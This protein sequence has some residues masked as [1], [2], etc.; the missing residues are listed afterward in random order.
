MMQVGRKY[1]KWL[2]T[3]G[4]LAV[5]AM[6]YVSAVQSREDL[7]KVDNMTDRMKTVCVGR[8]LIDVPANAQVNLRLGLVQG[9]EVARHDE[10][11]E[12]FATRLHARET[13]LS[14]K[15]NM[16][17][18]KNIESIKD[19]Q[20]LGFSGKVFVHGRYRGYGI[21][22]GQRRYFETISVEGYVHKAG[23][24][25]SFMANTYDPDQAGV[26]PALLT[27]LADRAEND[28]PSDPGFCIS[29]A[30]LRDSSSRARSES[31]AMSAS[32]PGHPDL[33]ILFWTNSAA[34]QG[35]SL[36]KRHEAAMG[37]LTRAR[38]RTLRE[39]ERT[40]N[41][42]AGEEV[43]IK[44]TELNFATVFSFVW[45]TP[46]SDDNV[47]IPHLS[48]EL[49][50]GMSPQAGGA[51]VQS[52]LSEEAVLLLWNKVSSSIRLRPTGP[53]KVA[54]TGTPPPPLGTLAEA[55]DRCPQSGW[56]LCNDASSGV[57]VLGG[58][59][60]YLC[61]G[62]KM[63]QA[64]LL[65][66][67]TLWQR[68]RGLQSSYE[69]STRT[70]W[71]LVDKR[72]RDRSVPALPLA[73]ATLA[74][75]ASGN[76]LDGKVLSGAEP[77]VAIGCIAK[78]GMQCPSSGWWRCEE[79]H[80][81]DGTR[82]FSVGS[83]LPAATFEIPSAAFGRAFGRAQAIQR[84]SVWRLMRHASAEGSESAESAMGSDP[85]DRRE[86]PSIS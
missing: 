44:V 72:E 77:G 19:V 60:Q 1:A 37:P 28:V 46:G 71:T 66:P 54:E 9:F 64:L 3:L 4:V 15:T 29:G 36:L 51:P 83:L 7:K 74:A 6:L 21:E 48:L 32:L 70:S 38:T 68:L 76:Q 30:L 20:N 82:W 78:T 11:Q 75:R 80:A 42:Y 43:A 24:T 2:L 33:G 84:R 59:R 81:L 52:S 5:T 23:A 57:N 62:Q 35:G 12:G 25:Y 10:S 79:S 61:K 22:R 26:L 53:G 45:E 41:G 67:Q 49:D 50:T 56:W 47:L 65:P 39:G 13:E 63:P 18:R 58:Q 73:Q 55:G 16:L 8:F 27:Q 17:G 40:I 69:V 34:A 14:A 31:V 86:P 85:L